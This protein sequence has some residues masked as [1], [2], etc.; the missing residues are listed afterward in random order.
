MEFHCS[1]CENTVAVD[2][3]SLF[4]KSQPCLEQLFLSGEPINDSGFHHSIN[5]LSE[6]LNQ[7]QPDWKTTIENENNEFKLLIACPNCSQ[8]PEQYPANLTDILLSF[9]LN[10][11]RLVETVEEQ[12]KL[13]KSILRNQQRR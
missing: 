5:D 9:N 8:S 1:F 12:N 7:Q 2:A 3:K 13:L 11:I 4:E 6:L 10:I